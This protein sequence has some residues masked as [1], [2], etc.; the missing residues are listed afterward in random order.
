MAGLRNSPSFG[1]NP[2]QLI[3][4]AQPGILP[5]FFVITYR[6]IVHVHV[7][8]H[9]DV[10]VYKCISQ[11]P[12]TGEYSDDRDAVGRKET[13]IN[14]NLTNLLKKLMYMYVNTGM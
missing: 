12:K 5:C 4:C 3:V 8:I 2:R 14:C 6:H 13:E 1:Q 9:V 10:D 7:H 11:C